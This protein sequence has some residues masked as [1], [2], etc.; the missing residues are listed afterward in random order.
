[1][2]GDQP[3]PER[4]ELQ[5]NLDQVFKEAMLSDHFIYAEVAVIDRSPLGRRNELVNEM[6]PA[7]RGELS[8]KPKGLNLIVPDIETISWRVMKEWGSADRATAA[9]VSAAISTT[10]ASAKGEYFVITG[11]QHDRPCQGTYWSRWL[12]SVDR[13][14]GR[15]I[16]LSVAASD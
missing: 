3:L 2:H 8:T 11:P 5:K 1:M 4:S 10:L 12:L 9:R 13:V 14:A 7:S 16:G 6:Y 15:C